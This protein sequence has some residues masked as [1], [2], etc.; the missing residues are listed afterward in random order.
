MS[1]KIVPSLFTLANLVFG[2]LSII[3]TM[4]EQYVLSGVMIILCMIMDVLDGKIARK[5]EVSSNFGKELDSLADVVSF[6]VAPAILVYAQ[7][8][9]A[10]KW[11][12][13]VVIIWFIMAGALRLARFNIQTTSGYFQGVPITAAGSLMALLNMIPDKISPIVFLLST[14][15]LGL[16]MISK[17]RVP[18]I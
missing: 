2:I 1:L 16:L 14:A 10:Y 3:Y 8:L 13:L 18:K 5:L 7:I 11:W 15:V 17:I 9:V 6:G 4:S 12:G